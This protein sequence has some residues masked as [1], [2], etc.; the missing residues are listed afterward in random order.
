MLSVYST[1]VTSVFLEGIFFLCAGVII[2]SFI[3][4][5]VSDE[6]IR[7]IIPQGRFSGIL[8]ASFVGLLFPVCEC[9]IVPVVAG[10]IRKGLPLPTAVTMLLSIPLVNLVTFTGTY[11]AFSG[12]P[13][14]AAARAAGGV[15]ISCVIGIAVSFITDKKKVLVD[16]R[17]E[18]SFSPVI[19][20]GFVLSGHDCS[21]GCSCH[22]HVHAGSGLPGATMSGRLW[23]VMRHSVEE[24]FDTGRFFIA[25]ILVTAMF[26]TFLP[27][28]IFSSVST[29]FPLPE[30]FMSGYAYVLSICSQTDAFVA[31]SM[32][33]HFSAGP[34]LCFMISGAMIDIKTTMMLRRVFRKRF[35]VMLAMGIV[36]L[37]VIYSGLAAMFLRWI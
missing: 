36:V 8:A 18:D 31:R 9:G 24:F 3:D 6:T 13:G 11:Y 29:M 26:Q 34:V 35:I 16:P 15:I 27:R 21:H 14:M 28:D 32:L 25:G 1:Y 37:S 12:T 33:P 4:V 30:L 2:S 22:G 10:L 20:D 19:V 23:E 7:K 17:L 5:F